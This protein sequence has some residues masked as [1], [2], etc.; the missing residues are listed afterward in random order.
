MTTHSVG[1]IAPFHG[2]KEWEAFIASTGQAVVTHEEAVSDEKE[3]LAAFDHLEADIE[4][5]PQPPDSKQVILTKDGQFT[6]EEFMRH[7]FPETRTAPPD[8]EAGT[9]D[10]VHE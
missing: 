3:I 4:F 6:P 7:Y 5:D 9:I 10:V 1:W 8:R 2:K